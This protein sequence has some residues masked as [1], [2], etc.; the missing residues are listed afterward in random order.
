M[1]VRLLLLATVMGLTC[2]CDSNGCGRTDEQETTTLGIT[3]P[4]D[5]TP[6]NLTVKDLP[7]ST[8]QLIA[9]AHYY[10]P[11]MSGMD[12]E[13]AAALA[14]FEREAPERRALVALLD[15]VFADQQPWRDFVKHLE[16]RLSGHTVFDATLSTTVNSTFAA[17][18]GVP[19]KLGGDPEHRLVVMASVMAPVY[20]IYEVQ[21]YPRRV[22]HS[23]S[24]AASDIAAEI[25]TAMAEQFGY[26]RIR[27][28]QGAIVLPQLVIG[29][30]PD[31]Q[32]TLKDALFS[33][34][35]L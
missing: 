20:Y 27:A 24:S 34:Y 14:K 28:N 1:S 31:Y 29:N 2:A 11:K 3:E 13:S 22:R 10:H 30:L 6:L 15:R 5:G 21:D 23:F 18:V 25:E 16:R 8:A 19:R 9:I 35:R 12:F 26:Q 4:H 7:L 33:D 17:I 32:A